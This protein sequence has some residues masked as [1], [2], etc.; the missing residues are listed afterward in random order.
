M[1]KYRLFF[2]TIWHKKNQII[3]NFLSLL[4]YLTL[5]LIGDKCTLLVSNTNPCDPAIDESSVAN[6][7]V[8]CPFH[9]TAEHV[10]L[11]KSS[12]I[13]TNGWT[14]QDGGMSWLIL[15]DKDDFIFLSITY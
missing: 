11:I 8:A 5:I 10:L 15:K 13:S 6:V 14:E 12:H 9:V 1:Y 3:M 7:I 4:I 2:Q